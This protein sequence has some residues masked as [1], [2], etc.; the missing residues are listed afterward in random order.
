[1]NKYRWVMGATMA[2]VCLGL[3]PRSLA[4]DEKTPA[5]DQTT[6]KME[7]ISLFDQ[8]QDTNVGNMP[9][10]RGITA[11]LTT[12]PAKEVKAYPKLNS[13]QPLYGC[14]I[15]NQDPEKPGKENSNKATKYYFVLDQSPQAV[16][17]AKPKE[18]KAGDRPDKD[19]SDKNKADKNAKP[20]AKQNNAVEVEGEE[21]ES[22]IVTN[23]P[24]ARPNAAGRYDLLYFDADHDLD[25]TND[26]VVHVVKERPKAMARWLGNEE[27]LS[28]FDAVTVSLA[29]GQSARLVPMM[30]ACGNAGVVNF[31]AAS[32][33]QGEI[34]LGKKAYKAT[35]SQA[36][37]AVG[38]FDHPA[39]P[40]ILT[41]VDGPKQPPSYWWMSTLGTM[42]EADGEF[43]S[44][45]ASPS[46]DRLFVRPYAGERGV[47]E[48]SAGKRDI[49]ELGLVGILQFK[50]A[51]F[52]LGDMSFPLPVDK[53]R[54]AKYR[55]PVGDYQPMLLNVDYGRLQVGLRANYNRP[56]GAGKT[57]GA[58]EI[59][60]DKPCVL[61]FSEKAEMQFLAPPQERVFK[62]GDAVSLAAMLAIPEKNLQLS[63]LTDTSKKVGDVK[64]MVDGKLQT[65]PR[66]A[67]LEPDV[68]ITNSAGKKLGGGKMPFG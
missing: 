47:L 36:D 38:R 43:Y 18:K 33:R 35:L 34:R 64:W 52:P 11:A 20:V 39:S 23:Q 26:P 58:L 59:R 66:Y 50:G 25:L 54:V 37:G 14:A 4:A 10:I 7:E 5:A 31:I 55:L 9:M 53:A 41:P 61:D 12:R 49:K 48:V 8:A 46:G 22:F 30:W 51:M 60:K 19:K 17:A 13:K 28:I 42:R 45:S 57:P 16:E 40:L 21:T 56:A 68:V 62:P 1:M 6:F 65:A 29:E 15:L 44:I 32:A 67:S 24:A 27:N 63:G 2:L 3:A